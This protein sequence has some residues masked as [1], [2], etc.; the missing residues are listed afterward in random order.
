MGKDLS[1]ENRAGELTSEWVCRVGEFKRG[2][3]A[4]KGGAS[5]LAEV[6]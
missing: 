1:H 3:S 6:Y 2:S 4:G 5:L